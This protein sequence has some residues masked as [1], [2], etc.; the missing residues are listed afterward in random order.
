MGE[1]A[2]RLRGI[3]TKQ[4]I[5]CILAII[6]LLVLCWLQLDI[7]SQWTN[8]WYTFLI[9]MPV[10]FG[11][12]SVL[13]L[14]VIYFV[15][16]AIFANLKTSGLILSI[17]STVISIVNYYVIEF[18]NSPLSFLELRNFGTAMNV[19]GSY[20][21]TITPVVIGLIALCA[22][23]MV[24]VH[25]PLR[26]FQ[27]QKV[28]GERSWKRTIILLAA[29]ALIIFVGY[30]GPAPIKPARVIVWNWTTCYP[31]YGYVPCTVETL[32]KSLN[33]V[34]KP[35]GYSDAALSSIEMPAAAQATAKPDVIFILNETFADI[36][37]IKDFEVDK[38]YLEGIH[39]LENSI[40][41]Y[42]VVPQVGGGTNKSEYEFL[43]SNSMALLMQSGA[44]FL[45]VDMKGAP[46]VVTLMEEQG[47]ETTAAHPREGVNYSRDNAYPAVGFD[48][49]YFDVDFEN[50]RYK[51]GRYCESDES[52]YKNLIRWYE[53][54]RK[55]N[56]AA[57]DDK[58]QFMYCL[59]MQNHGGYNMS[60]ANLDVVHAVGDFHGYGSQVNEYLTGIYDSDRAFMQLVDHFKNVD[61]P[62]IICMVGDHMPSFAKDIAD[63]DAYSTDELERR[64]R[65]TPFVIWANFDIEDANLGSIGMNSLTP[66]AL[67]T[68]GTGL[69]PY[70]EYI[71]QMSKD[72]PILTAYGSYYDAE[73]TCHSYEDEPV[74]EI[75]DYFYLEYA[76]I[77]KKEL[78]GW[79]TIDESSAD[80]SNAS[81][82]E[83][84]SE[85]G[86]QAA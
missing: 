61:R 74:Q 18:H 24:I 37:L 8:E 34:E 55:A 84:S 20:E 19:M 23:Q 71:L 15:L 63:A 35:S 7:S 26:R 44:P 48:N 82:S 73:G 58:P 65:T 49:I 17:L 50:L 4:R 77:L 60:P 31:Y 66:I 70:Y 75:S 52:T 29:S 86:K 62:V 64:L 16:Y 5:L 79:F 22:A 36:S 83:S 81:S 76:N 28:F 14:G 54:H 69:S 43:T 68:A 2:K 85:A 56:R 38:E 59:T 53:E 13:T 9:K 6:G 67:Q 21:I 30:L 12:L 80:G 1:K 40:Q 47:Y 27:K 3:F 11:V 41:G 33:L 51:R 46:S 45:S 39:N 78:P 10:I 57:G 72:Y 32:A 42:A 25:I